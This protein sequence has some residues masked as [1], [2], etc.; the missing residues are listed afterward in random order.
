[1]SDLHTMINKARNLLGPVDD[2]DAVDPEYRRA[3]VELIADS[4]TPPE[5]TFFSNMDQKVALI[6]S[7]LDAPQAGIDY[8]YEVFN[9]VSGVVSY[10]VEVPINKPIDGQSYVIITT[11]GEDGSEVSLNISEFNQIAET[12]RFLSNQHGPKE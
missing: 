7:E 5:G 11:E 12:V 3:L 1:M 10:Q 4:G 8:D 6:N 9:T 2:R